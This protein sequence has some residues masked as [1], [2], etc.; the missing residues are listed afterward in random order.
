MPR[1]EAR[2]NGSLVSGGAA[3][4]GGNVAR[5]ATGN[6]V[7]VAGCVGLKLRRRVSHSFASLAVTMVR[8]PPR[9][10]LGLDRSRWRR[11]LN[12]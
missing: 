5:E 3:G 7:T 10:G 11:G 9:F 4:L 12:R 6:K 1:S 2:S 8:V